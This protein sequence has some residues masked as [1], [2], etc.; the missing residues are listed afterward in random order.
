MPSAREIRTLILTLCVIDGDG[1]DDDDGDDDKSNG[2]SC[3]AANAF[4]GF[5]FHMAAV[6][7]RATDDD[8]LAMMFCKTLLRD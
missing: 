7:N 4:D 1:D 6:F 2:S 3:V 5:W 8:V